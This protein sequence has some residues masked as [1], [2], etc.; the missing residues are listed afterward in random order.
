MF[1]PTSLSP[2]A[3]WAVH[4]FGQRSL[5]SAPADATGRCQTHL[6]PVPQDEL[7]RIDRMVVSSDGS[8]DTTVGIYLDTVD[9]VRAIDG[10]EVGNFDVADLAAAIQLHGGT[11]MVCGWSGASLGAVGTLHV[12]WQILRRTG[13]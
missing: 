12:Q 10:T 4:D 2:A 3:A 6:G 9:P 5:T 13:G 7:W 1:L 11:A 8:T